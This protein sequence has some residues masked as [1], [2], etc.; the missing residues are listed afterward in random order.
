[1]WALIDFPQID[2]A[3]FRIELGSFTFAL[4]WYALA[5][6][7]GLLLGWRLVA[8]LCAR[9]QLWPAGR[10]PIHPSQTE[11]LLF[12][13]ALGVIIGGRLGYVLFYNPSHFIAHPLD[14]PKIWQGGMSF[15]GGFLGVCVASLLF[16]RKFKAPLLSLGDAIAC[17]A[18]IG[19]FFG[20]LANFI[21]A[22]LWGRPTDVPW[23][24]IFPTDPAQVPR[25][26]S[27]LYEAGLEGM[28]LFILLML[29]L[30]RGALR[31]PGRMIGLFL[32]GYGL[33]RG[34]VEFFRQPDAGLDFLFSIGGI[35]VS[36]GQLLSL[37]MLLVG[38]VLVFRR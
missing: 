36:M 21:N 7:A 8:R 35:G 38:L 11:D 30:R 31:K 23:A 4:R 17:A 32:M 1:M 3:I 37:P 26:P 20:R 18:P 19:I 25:H 33:A 24:M 14:I 10:P 12:W 16:A 15:H 6:I 9:P 22:E 13:L 34:F 29:A 2:P 27:Q 28:L 5:Y